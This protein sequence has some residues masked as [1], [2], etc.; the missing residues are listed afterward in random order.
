MPPCASYLPRKELLLKFKSAKV[1]KVARH[2]TLCAVHLP[3]SF[4]RDQIFE[5]IT[6]DILR[7][8]YIWKVVFEFHAYLCLKHI[9]YSK[10]FNAECVVDISVCFE[11]LCP[12]VHFYLCFAAFV[13]LLRVWASRQWSR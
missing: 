2:A 5:V 12:R 3:S 8:K 9:D 4:P 13:A 6:P 11:F 10:N 1:A 7:R